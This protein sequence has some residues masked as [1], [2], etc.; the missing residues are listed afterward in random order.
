MG[1][2]GSSKKT[3]VSTSVSRVVTD[4][5]IVDPNKKAMIQAVIKREN[6]SD[7][8]VEEQLNSQAFDFEHMYR[9][10][11]SGKYFYGLPS[12]REVS[13]PAAVPLVKDVIEASEGQQVFI[14]YLKID[15]PIPKHFGYQYLY[16]RYKYNQLTNEINDLSI[17]KG[18]PVYLKKMVSYVPVDS[19]EDIDFS[20]LEL[21]ASIPPADAGDNAG[22]RTY[23]DIFKDLQGVGRAN[24]SKDIVY[25]LEPDEVPH[26]E[27]IYG[28]ET[29]QEVIQQTEEGE[30]FTLLVKTQHE[31]SEV[32]YLP[33][34][35]DDSPK[36]FYQVGFTTNNNQYGFWTYQT[37]TSVHPVLD[38]FE[39]VQ[40]TRDGT[41]FP[42]AIFRR[43]WQDRTAEKYRDSEEFKSTKR[44][45][46]FLDID[47][48]SLGASIHENPD[49]ND[50]I[51][52]AMIMAV[53]MN[54]ANQLE[55]EYL[56]EFFDRLHQKGTN[57]HISLSNRR[58][59]EGRNSITWSDAD[60]SMTL[61]HNGVKKKTIGESFGKPGD[62]TIT[63]SNHALTYTVEVGKNDNER[64][65]FVS[66][67]N[68]HIKKQLT[69]GLCRVI[70]VIN[71]VAKYDIDRHRSY[72]STKDNSIL[73]I[74]LDYL[75]TRKYT[76]KE[77]TELYQRSLHLVF[78]A[79]VTIKLKWYE[80][81][82]F[83]FV[84]LVVAVVI[85][86]M[87]GGTAAGLV[88]T[89]LE[90]GLTALAIA[91]VVVYVTVLVLVQYA[92]RLV[93]KEMGV[94]A[95]LVI[96]SIM[97]AY[98]GYQAFTSNMPAAQ[99]YMNLASNMV[100]ASS[101]V[102]EQDIAAITQEGVELAATRDKQ[103][104]E[105]DEALKLLDTND[106]LD[107]F[108]FIGKKPM[109]I[110]GE[111]PNDFYARTVHMGSPVDLAYKSI[112]HYVDICL[113]LPETSTAIGDTV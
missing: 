49:I 104:K 7:A 54:T 83:K 73:L 40:Y 11:K 107:P 87:S 9:Y 42:F 36:Q 68:Y 69:S 12:A 4:E 22:R 80:T 3:Y 106:F 96:A 59:I 48:V 90:L 109:L 75:T 24:T 10:A 65:R 92:F 17:A 20:I 111:T 108:A 91:I 8:I 28:W 25:L 101:Y 113:T 84:L 32:K 89:A 60:F 34:S 1:L 99:N 105:I 5:Q 39:E 103:Q 63:T 102:M 23:Q 45:L 15:E 66:Y 14:E 88:A 55:G 29:E 74:P 16:D 37:G 112:E 85:A 41:Y 62:I 21:E 2:F 82:F 86:V 53:P 30:E 70:T 71:P 38:T 26:V 31:D 64:T 47:F 77:R 13:E 19:V 76:I 94:E 52:S 27:L 98:G 110:P 67:T 100:D 35:L 6:I 58:D 18:V 57:S 61:S 78:N 44:L 33:I 95:A 81:A 56:Y 93:V 51:Q 97:I 79:K 50:V 46:Q 72:E 43:Q